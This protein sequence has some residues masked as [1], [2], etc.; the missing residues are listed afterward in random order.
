MKSGGGRDVSWVLDGLLGLEQ[1]GVRIARV[2]C[3]LC[4]LVMMMM[5]SRYGNV[6]LTEGWQW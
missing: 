4:V 6:E 3:G 2:C 1:S 5:E